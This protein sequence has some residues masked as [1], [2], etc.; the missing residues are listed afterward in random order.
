[1]T[2][3]FLN[4]L[5]SIAVNVLTGDRIGADYTH[6]ELPGGRSFVPDAVVEVSSEEEVSS[7]L[8]LC[9]DNGIPVTVRGAG[10]GLVGGSVAI[11]GGIVMSMKGMD[12]IGEYDEENLCVDVQPGVLL[13]DLKADADK[14]NFLY[15]PDPGEK[16]ATVG[17]NA[18][19]NAGGPMAFKYGSTRDNILAAHVVLP[20]GELI[21]L[22]S[23]T[24]KNNSGYALLQLILGS[25]GT[26]GVITELTCKLHPKVKAEVSLILP[27]PDSDSCINAARKIIAEQLDLSVVEYIDTELVEFSGKITGSPVFPVT[28]NGDPVGASLLITIEGKSDDELDSALEAVAEMSEELGCLDIL[29]VDTPSL[30]RDVWAAHDAFHTSMEKA[31]NSIEI[32]V[33]VPAS[34]MAE[35]IDW[36][37]EESARLGL[38]SGIYGHV[39]DGGLHVHIYS[40]MDHDRFVSL[41]VPFCAEAQSRCAS[42]GGAVSSE[43]GIGYAWRDALADSIGS[44]PVELMRRIKGAFDPAGILNPGKVI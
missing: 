42:Y 18:S 39:G 36:V 8:K 25:E 31:V 37:K 22:G 7:V 29:V 16:T 30:K 19:T 9:S 32:N 5:R 44:G 1:M 3:A 21:K 17:G 4:E 14:H 28:Q 6:D 24:R 27:F 10:T 34:R 23:V 26:L 2:E 38:S 12:K 43:Y 20:T 40:D 33:A 41:A 15:A 13:Q 11:N 35:Y